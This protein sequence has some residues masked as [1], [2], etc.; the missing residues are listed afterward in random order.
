MTSPKIES[1]IASRRRFSRLG[2]FRSVDV[3]GSSRTNTTRSKGKLA[4]LLEGTERG[5]PFYL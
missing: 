1:F 3:E 4:K 5:S 2:C